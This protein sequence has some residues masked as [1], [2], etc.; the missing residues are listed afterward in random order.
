LAIQVTVTE[1]SKNKFGNLSLYFGQHANNPNHLN[2]AISKNQFLQT[3][4]NFGPS[5]AKK[6]IPFY[7]LLAGQ[8]NCCQVGKKKKK[9]F[10]A[11]KEKH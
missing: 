11:T 7:E 5:F 2:L 9:R 8:N 10:L 3:K 6:K 1:E 4:H